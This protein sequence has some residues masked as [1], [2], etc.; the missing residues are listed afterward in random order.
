M[1]LLCALFLF[2][3]LFFAHAGVF[4]FLVSLFSSDH[5]ST[6]SFN[7]NS[8]NIALLQAALNSDPNPSK[9]GGDITIV[10]DSALLPDAGPLGTILD[11]TEDTSSTQ[12]SV[13]VV[14]DGDSLSQIAKMF[15]VSVNT[16]VWANDIERGDLIRPG[17]TLIILPVTGI[18]YTVAKGDTLSSIAKK[19]GGDI[20]EIKR[21]NNIISD[22]ELSVGSIVVVPDGV[23]ATP[24]STQKS[25]AAPLRNAGGPA[26]VGYYIKPVSGV[27]T[28]G[29]HGYNGVDLAA[30]YGTPVVASAGGNVIIARPSGWNGG[31]GTYAVVA[32]S[33]GTQTL[34]AHL[35]AII[36]SQGTTVVQGQVLGYSG[37]SGRSTGPHLHFEVRG[38]KNPF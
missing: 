25:Y 24:V 8:Q 1:F 11:I 13:Y 14:R 20:D 27:R 6:D 4:S 26:Y 32:H 19:Y 34:Y 31:Y 23:L 33:N 35:G 21:F 37:S 16:I 38:A 12:I 17:E 7:Q 10:G 28:Q 3:P 36:V 15:K 2:V 5:A 29:L 9:G 18:R 30:P 22:S